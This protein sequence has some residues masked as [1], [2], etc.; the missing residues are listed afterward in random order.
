MGPKSAKGDMFPLL[1]PRRNLR[2]DSSCMFWDYKIVE[3]IRK[4]SNDKDKVN[5]HPIPMVALKNRH[6]SDTS[7]TVTHVDLQSDTTTAITLRFHYI[8]GTWNI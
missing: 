7:A 3:N 2:V 1:N 4:H 5:R 8:G 6:F